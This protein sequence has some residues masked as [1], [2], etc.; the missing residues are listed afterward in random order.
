MRSFIE[1][2]CLKIVQMVVIPRYP[3]AYMSRNEKVHKDAKTKKIGSLFF[4]GSIIIIIRFIEGMYSFF[5]N[6]I[7]TDKKMCYQW[8]E[9]PC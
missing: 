6:L 5:L 7:Q 2:A 3:Y 1:L 4:H 9:K 8:S